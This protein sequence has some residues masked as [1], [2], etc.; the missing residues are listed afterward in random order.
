MR[1]RKALGLKAPKTYKN[2]P[3]KPY[4]FD[5]EPSLPIGSSFDQFYSQVIDS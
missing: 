2:G 3:V 4:R 1:E 5:K